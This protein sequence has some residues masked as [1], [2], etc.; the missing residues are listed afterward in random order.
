MPWPRRPDAISTV[1]SSAT[2]KLLSTNSTAFTPCSCLN[3]LLGHE[4]IVIDEFDGIHTMLM[5]EPQDFVDDGAGVFPDPPALVNGGNGTEAAQE[6]TTK[7]GVVRHRPC[8]EV[9]PPD[10]S[11]EIDTVIR[12]RRQRIG[13]R[14]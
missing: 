9:R 4:E 13:I 14:H 10:V 6:G 5:L 2:K 12:D 1:L 8:A 11:L 3:N 7:T